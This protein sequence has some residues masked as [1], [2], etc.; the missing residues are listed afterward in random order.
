VA[1]KPPFVQRR[2][3]QLTAAL[4]VGAFAVMTV[5][6]VTNGLRQE[7]EDQEASDAATTRRAAVQEWQS[8]LEGELGKLGTISPGVPPTL[9]LPLSSTIDGLAAGDV[10]ADAEASI[11]DTIPQVKAAA[12][13]L[14]DFD[15][16][17]AI[18]DQG[19][20]VEETNYLLNSQARVAHALRLYE[21][22]AL[23]ARLALAAEGER[24]VALADRAVAIRDLAQSALNEGWTDYQQVLFATGLGQV[25]QPTG[26]I[27]GLGPTGPTG[28]TGAAGAVGASGAT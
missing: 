13:T 14:E 10:R 11:E 27:P 18:A 16:T 20:D 19:F 5:V 12:K 24:R 28:A 7:R 17:G 25:P 8:T 4:L 26:I 21:Q 2:W 9:L 3:V 22:A 15:L 6:W 1:V 23:L